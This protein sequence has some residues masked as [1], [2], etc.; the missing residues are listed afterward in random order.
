M[1]LYSF[2]TQTKEDMEHLLT[3]L[4]TTSLFFGLT[5]VN[6]DKTKMMIVDRAELSHPDISMI[7]NC[8]VVQSYVYLGSTITST[9]GCEDE[10][11]RRCA[12]TRSAVDKLKRFW[13]NDNIAK[14]TK[15]RLMR[16]LVFPIFCF[17][18]ILLDSKTDAKSMHSRCG[19]GGGCCGSLGQRLGPTFRS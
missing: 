13:C 5:P 3:L 11:R 14:A 18:F 6:R 12:I 8:E 1:I 2:L 15:V 19:A 17:I 7:G 10:I 9:G 4:E 16:S